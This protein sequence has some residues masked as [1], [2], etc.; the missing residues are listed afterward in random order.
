MSSAIARLGN[1][2]PTDVRWRVQEW[3]LA[4]LRF[5]ITRA[6]KD[7]AAVLGVASEIDSLGLRPGI[8]GPSFFRRTSSEICAAITA[9]D[10]PQRSDILTRHLARIEDPRLRRA[11]QAA[12]DL[13]ASP[14]SS[15]HADKRQH[16]WV[17][18]QR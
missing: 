4:L 7:E 13:D 3:L 11:I 5:A 14:P 6:R 12:F 15:S 18:L 1:A 10:D 16:L 2:A 8:A 17:G 9:P